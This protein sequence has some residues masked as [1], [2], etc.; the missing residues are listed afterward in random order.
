MT[1]RTMKDAR[2]QARGDLVNRYAGYLTSHSHS[3]ADF[4]V[5]PVSQFVTVDDL[6]GDLEAVPNLGQHTGRPADLRSKRL[7][8]QS[9]Y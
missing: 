6:G 8:S 9:I 3:S 4:V 7:T 5:L 1:L 2:A